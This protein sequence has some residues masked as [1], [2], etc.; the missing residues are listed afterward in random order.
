MGWC[1]ENLLLFC[2]NV[3]SLLE[4][5]AQTARGSFSN[6]FDTRTPNEAEVEF[7]EK[8]RPAILMTIIE[9]T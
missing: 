6:V 9:R 8:G 7:G 1:E 3:I 4:G 2:E 5:E